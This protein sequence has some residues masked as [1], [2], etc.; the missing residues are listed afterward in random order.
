MGYG[1]FSQTDL[2]TFL[3]DNVPLARMANSVHFRQFLFA[4]FDMHSI[5]VMHGHLTY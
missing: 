4:T 5:L 1:Y 3:G 2:V